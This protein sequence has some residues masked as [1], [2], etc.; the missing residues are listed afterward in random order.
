M[1]LSFI[2]LFIM[3]AAFTGGM[4]IATDSTAGERERGSLEPLLVNPAPRIAIAGGKWLAGTRDRDAHA[5]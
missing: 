1:I 5:C 3:L 2:P 4:Q